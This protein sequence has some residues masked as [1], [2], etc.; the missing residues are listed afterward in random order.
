MV[1]VYGP[2]KHATN[3]RAGQLISWGHVPCNRS[4]IG[5]AR[6]GTKVGKGDQQLPWG[7]AMS[8]AGAKSEQPL[9]QIITI[10]SNSYSPQLEEAIPFGGRYQQNPHI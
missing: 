9:L 10:H 4:P 7:P 5:L 2:G 1:V 3:L 8:I 6:V